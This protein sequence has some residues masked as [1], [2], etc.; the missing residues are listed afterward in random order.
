MSAT[1][2]IAGSALTTDRVSPTTNHT[3][4]TLHQ[5]AIRHSSLQSN[6]VPHQRNHTSNQTTITH[7]PDQEKS[8][9]NSHLPQLERRVGL[10]QHQIRRRSTQDDTQSLVA[11]LNQIAYNK[12][13]TTKGYTEPS[14][15]TELQL[16]R[17]IRCLE[18]L[19]QDLPEIWHRDK[20]D[21]A[22]NHLDHTRMHLRDHLMHTSDLINRIS[23][24]SGAKR[25]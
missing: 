7:V 9:H 1:L 20:L 25:I 12:H 16:N 8:N 22:L 5:A 13:M 23:C 3:P 11:Q 14:V 4:H 18:L 19:R 17:A 21:V 15:E 2:T 24:A 6:L 10:D